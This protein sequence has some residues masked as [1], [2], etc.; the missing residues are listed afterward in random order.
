MTLHSSIRLYTS[1]D[2]FT[3]E[4]VTNNSSGVTENVVIQRSTGDIRLHSPASKVSSDEEV[5][6]IY[7][8]MGFIRLLAGEYMVVI[9]ERTKIGRIG[10]NDIYKV[11]DYKVLPLSRNNLALT[12]AK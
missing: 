7:G 6:T 3:L 2:T 11:K 1:A 12:E 4:P 10:D 5:M 8:V 9:T